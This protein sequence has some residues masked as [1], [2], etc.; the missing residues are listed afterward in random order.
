MVLAATP[1]G[2]TSNVEP[3]HNVV[4]VLAI[5]GV[6]F[7]VTVTEKVHPYNWVWKELLNR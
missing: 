3:L 6:G 1:V 2:S 7:T 4:D 5:T